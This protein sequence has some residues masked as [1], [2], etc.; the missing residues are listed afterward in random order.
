MQ[1][2]VSFGPEGRMLITQAL[3]NKLPAVGD[4]SV[5]RFYGI[6][7]L[8]LEIDGV[9][10]YSRTD[11]LIKSNF[12]KPKMSAK[13]SNGRLCRYLLNWKCCNSS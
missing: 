3:L 7:K 11:L 6:A 2:E 12:S 1:L 5:N 8:V 9:S 10:Q 4:V 13:K